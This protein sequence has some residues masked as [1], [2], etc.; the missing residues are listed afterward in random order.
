MSQRRPRVKICGV[1]T[2]SDALLAVRLGADY[3]GLNFHPPSPRY[4]EPETAAE[5]ATAVREATGN[6]GLVNVGLVGV[7]VNRPTTEVETVAA[8]VGLDLIQLHGDETP[9]EVAAWGGRSIKAFRVRERFE[10]DLVKGYETAWGYLVDY[11]D[12]RLFGGSGHSWDFA[13]LDGAQLHKPTFI[14]GGLGPDNVR[15]AIVAANPWGI[16]VCSGVESTPGKKDPELL[17]Q[18]FKEIEH[19]Q[20]PVAS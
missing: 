7:F 15:A 13:S 10:A 8:E 1:T 20:G 6:V 17:E 14:A 19:G 12:P 5:I 3:L 18:L 4:V 2:T 9:A 11:R 16:D